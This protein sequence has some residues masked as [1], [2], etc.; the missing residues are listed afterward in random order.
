[1]P[2]EPTDTVEY[3]KVRLEEA[4]AL[5]DR[6]RLPLVAVYIEHSLEKL[7]VAKGVISC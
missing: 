4:R 3:L 7:D 1:M 5:A 6:L 2:Q